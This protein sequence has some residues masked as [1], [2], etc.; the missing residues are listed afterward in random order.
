MFTISNLENDNVKDISRILYPDID[1]SSGKIPKSYSLNVP[2]RLIFSG[3]KTAEYDNYFSNC[4]ITPK[5]SLY[6]QS[7]RD[8]AIDY[9]SSAALHK[10]DFFELMFVL[11]G[12]IYVNIENERHVYRKGDSCI[13][14]RNVMHTEEY[15]T[16]F[17]IVF[18]QISTALMRQLNNDLNLH[19]FDIE[20]N[21]IA[22]D[23]TEFMSKNLSSD[24]DTHKAYVDFIPVGNDNDI[25]KT[26]HD[27]FD[28]ITKE[29]LS[30]Q[31]GSTINV[32][33]ILQKILVYLSQPNNF[34]TTPIQIGSTAERLIF[35]EIVSAMEEV[36]GRI[37]RSQLSNKLNYS[38]TY[39]NKLCKKYSG[40]SLFDYSMTFCMKKA[41]YLLTTTSDNITNIG[42][43]LGFSNKTHFY[44]KFK[45]YYGLTPAEYR[46]KNSQKH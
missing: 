15:K 8:E 21:N 40:K 37:T 39:L 2:Y 1:L 19:Y 23:M 45:E 44:K 31:V 24:T 17:E 43:A 26:L 12:N 46:Q 27:Y 38:G 5:I 28:Q 3:I 35:E 9:L 33:H 10:H 42:I 30:P 22:S 11:S 6:S 36:D 14:N 4:F 18:L 25:I 29:T 41:A 20:K 13:L 7:N 16:D 32:L 34:S